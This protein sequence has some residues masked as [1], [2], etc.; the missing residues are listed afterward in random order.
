MAR[1]ILFI[2]PA[3]Y[4]SLKKKGVADMILER[5]E[6]G[7][8]EKVITVHPFVKKSKVIRLN[9]IHTIYEIGYDLPGSNFLT[10]ILTRLL[11]PAH[12]LKL[13]FIIRRIIKTEQINIIRSTDPFFCG[14]LALIT[15]RVSRIPYCISIHADYSK[16]YE[17]AGIKNIHGISLP[18]KLIYFITKLVLSKASLVMPIRE[19]LVSW[20]VNSGADEKKVFTIPH[21]IDFLALEKGNDI[22]IFDA[23]KIPKNKKIISFVGRLSKENYVYDI[24]EVVKKVSRKRNNFVLL[25]AGDGAE[26]ENLKNIIKNDRILCNNIKI[27]DFQPRDICYRLRKASAVSLCLMGGFSLIEACAAASPVISY[28]VEWH[29]ELIKDGVTGFLISEGNI[30]KV[31]EKIIFLFNNPEIARDVGKAAY[32]LVYEKHS[33]AQTSLVKKKIYSE[34]LH[35]E[36]SYGQFV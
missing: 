22:D 28:D 17:L 31:A 23:F 34:L 29:Y 5:D 20:A 3:D 27:L 32:Q 21:G 1:R 13:L 33:I 25:M 11:L 9:N 10:K 6:N 19:S 30:E 35:K 14:V 15:S 26:K 7:F 24:I 36:V 8:F 4:D 2:V 16:L 12:T 18:P